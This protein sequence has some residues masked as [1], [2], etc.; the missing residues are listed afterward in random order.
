MK[1]EEKK[2]KRNR[3]PWMNFP[4]NKPKKFELCHVENNEGD[5]ICGWWNGVFWEFGRRK[6]QGTIS[7]WKIAKKDY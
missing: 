2:S 5:I 7:K 3:Y 6:L 1:V 4:N